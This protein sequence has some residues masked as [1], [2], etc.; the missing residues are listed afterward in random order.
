MSAAESSY[1]L[2]NCPIGG[3]V[4]A[5]FIFRWFTESG[6]QRFQPLEAGERGRD[7]Y[8]R[9]TFRKDLPIHQFQKM[10]L[11]NEWSEDGDSDVWVRIE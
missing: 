2:S 1:G 10:R 8:N 3:G 4:E 7:P 6:I 9:A 11:P 5:C